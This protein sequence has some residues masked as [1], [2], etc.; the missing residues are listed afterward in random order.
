MA[1]TRQGRIL[2]CQQPQYSM[3]STNVNGIRL[4]APNKWLLNSLY[5]GQVVTQ[6][7]IRAFSSV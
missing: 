4:M 3:G 5:S 1:A 2:F 7:C 6:V